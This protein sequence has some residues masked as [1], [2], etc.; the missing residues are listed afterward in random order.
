MPEKKYRCMFEWK[1]SVLHVCG[2]DKDHK[3]VHECDSALC[4]AEQENEKELFTASFINND[5]VVMQVLKLRTDTTL[6]DMQMA[7]SIASEDIWLILVKKGEK[8]FF[9]FYPHKSSLI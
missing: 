7:F 3:G 6:G 5:L 8:E 2:R 4:D 9:S 1:D